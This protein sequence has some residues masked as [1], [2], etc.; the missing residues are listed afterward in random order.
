MS[1]RVWSGAALLK[2][3]FRG[4][5]LH[6]K[7]ASFI[8]GSLQVPPK[9]QVPPVPPGP[10]RAGRDRPRGRVGTPPPSESRDLPHTTPLRAYSQET[11]APFFWGYN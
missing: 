8:L 1:I 3:N 7:K 9:V 4:S 10:S 2:P 6:P 5:L 11:A